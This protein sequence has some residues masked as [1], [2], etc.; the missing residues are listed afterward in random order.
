MTTS[1]YQDPT[2]ALARLR[3][4]GVPV[5]LLTQVL[6]VSRQTIWSWSR[7]YTKPPARVRQGLRDLA[8]YAGPA[9]ASAT[10]EGWSVEELL[11]LFTDVPTE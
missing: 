5:A 4:L 8:E 7:G 2:K 1:K 3:S 9:A 10:F 11:S 6:N